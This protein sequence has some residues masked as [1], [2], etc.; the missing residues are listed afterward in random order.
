[1]T[2]E[3]PNIARAFTAGVPQP[4]PRLQP[5]WFHLKACSPRGIFSPLWTSRTDAIMGVEKRWSKLLI[6]APDA[7]DEV[8]LCHWSLRMPPPNAP[9]LLATVCSRLFVT[10]MTTWVCFAYFP[11]SRNLHHWYYNHND[12]VLCPTFHTHISSV[13]LTLKKCEQF[14]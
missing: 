2:V 3:M 13:S 5:P 8:H 12:T 14:G 11:F 1:M 9:Y 6:G 10:L 4:V 7:S